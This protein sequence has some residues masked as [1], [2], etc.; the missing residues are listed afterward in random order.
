MLFLSASAAPRRPAAP[1]ALVATAAFIVVAAFRLGAQTAPAT[2]APVEARPDFSGTWALD[3][4]ISND[5][6]KANFEPGQE[7]RSSR[8]GGFG[9]GSR[10][11]GGFGG[12]GG[13]RPD[14]RDTGASSTPDERARLQALT[15]WLKKT[16]PAFMR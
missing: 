15:D 7:N 9:S 14:T 8:P 3:R 1:A 10:R 5:A 16:A 4:S 6:S 11:R 13:A 12:F 2:A